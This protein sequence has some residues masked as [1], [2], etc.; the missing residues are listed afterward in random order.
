MSLPDLAGAAGARDLFVLRRVEGGR[1]FNLGGVGRGEAWAGN[2]TADPGAE[3]LLAQALSG[4]LARR[5]S[6]VP[7]RAFGPYWCR[8]AAAVA[9]G[10]ALVVLGGD[11]LTRDD[12]VLG[13]ALG[14]AASVPAPPPGK[15]EADEAEVRSAVAAVLASAGRSLSEAAQVIAT[16]AARAL[17]CEFGAVLLTAPLPRLFLAAEGWQPAGSEDELIAALLPLAAAARAG[18]LV[19]Q[20]TRLSAFPYPPLS[21]ADGLVARCV[22]PLAGQG[23]LVVAHAGTQPRGFTE[24]CQRVARELGSAASDVLA[25][26]VA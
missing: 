23:V 22:V 8:D 16:A 5:T 11:R 21:F 1:F 19:E 14:A 7:Q 9:V 24:L 2:V 20:D 25:T 3:P 4:G 15:A 10:D 6:G 17:S 26:G 12:D 13:A 18:A